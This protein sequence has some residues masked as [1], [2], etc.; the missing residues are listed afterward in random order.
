[1]P[2]VLEQ[3]RQSAESELKAAGFVTERR[4]RDSDAQRGPRHRARTPT[5]APRLPRAP[6]SDH[7]LDRPADVHGPGRP[8]SGP[9]QRRVDELQAAGFEVEVVDEDTRR[10][11]PGR[12]RASIRTRRPGSR[13]SR[14]PGSRSSSVASPSPSTRPAQRRRGPKRLT[15]VRVA[16]LMGGRS[17]E[18]DISVTSARSVIDA[19]DPD[20]YEVREIEIGRD[21]RWELEPGSREQSWARER[22]AACPF[23]PTAGRSSRSERSTS[24]SPSCT[25]P[26]ART[27]P[28]R[29]SSS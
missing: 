25:G 29:G 12:G 26:S 15:R 2:D 23:R 7:R 22:P 20:R 24:S 17:S 19:L 4:V 14:A 10:P 5:R 8:R 16:V 6:P 27:A 21:G 13:R 1:M 11:D 9:G 18:H 28:F 3:T